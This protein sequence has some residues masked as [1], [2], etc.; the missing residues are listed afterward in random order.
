MDYNKIV[1]DIIQRYKDA[2]V[3]IEGTGRGMPNGVTCLITR[4]HIAERF[5]DIDN[6]WR[7]ERKDRRILEIGSYL[8][9]VCISLKE[10][11][12]NVCALDI[13]EF[14]QA[15]PLKALYEKND[16]PFA[17]ANLRNH[18]LPYESNSFDA[19]IICEVIEHLNFNPL[20]V[21]QEINR[22]MKKDGYLYIGMPNQA[23]IQ[24]RIKLLL[25]RSVHTPVDE[26]LK[27]SAHC[28]ALAGIHL[29]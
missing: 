3:D 28:F 17:G 14:C 15:A 29:G 20:P 25:G 12:Y 22:V 18:K 24:N 8:G 27:H 7:G 4:I 21:L 16:I 11:G 2:P 1:Q 23:R 6:L 9:L 5:G 19:V 10:I 13:P 26:F